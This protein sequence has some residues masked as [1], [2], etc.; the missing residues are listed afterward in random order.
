MQIARDGH[1]EELQDYLLS[2]KQNSAVLDSLDS[3]RNSALHYASRYS[4]LAVV[5]TL[6]APEHKV[7]VDNVGADGMTPLHYAARYGIRRTTVN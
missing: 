3:K 7:T 6:L 2:T 5:E 1:L 4:H